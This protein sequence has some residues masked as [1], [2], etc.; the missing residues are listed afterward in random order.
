M[1]Q[2][3]STGVVAP[4][5]ASNLS[6][7]ILATWFKPCFHDASDSAPIERSSRVSKRL[8]W[9]ESEG[10]ILTVVPS[11]KEDEIAREKSRFWFDDWF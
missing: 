2:I 1:G 8:L 7:S 4:L 11:L 3:L 5:R 6:S 10:L 9:K